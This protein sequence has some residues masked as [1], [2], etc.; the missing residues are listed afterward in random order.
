MPAEGEILYLAVPDAS[1]PYL[2]ARVRWPDIAQ[3]ISAGQTEWQ[4]D[5]GLFDLPYDKFSAGITAD[6]AAAIAENW[7]AYLPNDDQPILD[8]PS[9]IRRMPSNWSN[10][11][12]AERRAWG[13]DPATIR[14]RNAGAYNR[15]TNPAVRRSWWAWWRREPAA[16]AQVDDLRLWTED[17][18]GMDAD[19][20]IMEAADSLAIEAAAMEVV[21]AQAPDRGTVDL[22][23]VKPATVKPATVKP[24][25][26][27][28][29]TVK[30]ATV[31]A[32]TV[33]H[34][35]VGRNTADHDT[36]PAISEHADR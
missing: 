11:S 5:L 8:A 10:L 23:T 31:K 33:R 13:L 26:V 4:N 14:R 2:L 24:A 21:A 35:T 1:E 16:T 20:I 28:P 27:K 3:A 17:A 9:L 18:I 22:A 19:A 36:P 12:P 15:S 29:A 7:G 32:E 25:T 34:G 6:R 30:P